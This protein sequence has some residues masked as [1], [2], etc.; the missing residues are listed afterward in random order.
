VRR[1][2]ALFILVTVSP[3]IFSAE[4]DAVSRGKLALECTPFIPGFWPP[5][6]YDH[7]WKHWGVKEKPKD[8]DA[9]FR[10]RYGLHESPYANG[11]YPMG[12]REAP[13]VLAT[14]IGIDCMMCHAG[15]IMGKSMVGLGNTSLEIHSLFEDLY[16]A[17]G[18]KA[19]LPF[20]FSQSRGTN[21]AGAFG[22]YLLGLRMPD[23][24]FKAEFTNLG[25]KDDSVEDT[26][27]WWHLKKKKSMYFTGDTDAR[28]V[29]ALMQFMMHPLAGPG[30]FKKHEPA[31]RDVQQYLLSI[32][33]PKY[34]FAIDA[35]LAAKG[36]V[37]FN[38]NCAKCHGTYEKEWT[39]PNKVI[40]L[41]EIGTDPNR[42]RNIGKLYHDAYNASWFA[43][44]SPAPK[45]M[46]ESIGYQ[47]PPLD[48]IWATAPYFHNG[49]VPTLAG[50]LNSKARPKL[51]TRSF[52]TDEAAY[53]KANVGWKVRDVK[54]VDPK[55]TAF[56][57]RKI[58]DTTMPGR[59]NAGHEYGDDLTPDERKAVIE[60]L[61]TL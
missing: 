52:K 16:K 57:K 21:E 55:L 1:V 19:D 6:A 51:F 25:L 58:Y 30:D 12:L 60:Y 18:L 7:A 31:F 36:K 28:S 8:Y 41:D 50:V 40:P 29:R 14:G 2:V 5:F 23:L 44:E 26:P 15:S 3:A 53:D 10:E 49:S 46:K 24:T 13:L 47:A 54:D 32:E 43:K 27:P 11:R 35:K 38:D 61:K 48:G 56:E 34:P 9:A 22:V 4:P 59:S 17:G 39:Y 45:P 20:T 37:V 33:P 42:F